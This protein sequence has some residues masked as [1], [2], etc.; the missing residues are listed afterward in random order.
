[1]LWSA[2]APANIALIKYMG[3]QT[4]GNNRPA[5]ASLS[6]TLNQL[7]SHVTLEPLAGTTDR[8]LPL[9][10]EGAALFHLNIASQERFLRHLSNLKA[11]FH[12]SGGFLVKSNN[13]FPHGTGLASSASSFAALTQCA[14][15]ALSELTQMPIPSIEEQAM[16]SRQGSGSS[17]RSFFTPW[18][19]WDDEQVSAIELPYSSLRHQVIVID[20]KEKAVSSSAA[21]Q[22]ILSSPFYA[23]RPKQAQKHLE[24]LLAALTAKQWAVAFDTCWQEFQDMHRLFSTCETPFSYITEQ[25]QGALQTLQDLWMR[26]GDGPLVTM[27]AGPNIHLL[28]RSDQEE[29]QRQFTWDHLQGRYDFL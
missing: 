20:K 24:R 29:Q 21:H 19:L 9:A 3:K 4:T 25:T 12:Y 14:I 11:Y 8:W 1:M 7:Q 13:N 16:L 22:R 18:A 2:Q 23:T 5:N 15:K 27:D 17:C 26:C 28:Y 6:Y 10:R